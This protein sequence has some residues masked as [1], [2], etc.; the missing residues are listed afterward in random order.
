MCLSPRPLSRLLQWCWRLPKLQLR[1]WLPAWC[2]P[3]LLQDSAG[4]Q[5]SRDQEPPQLQLCRVQHAFRVGAQAG[6]FNLSFDTARHQVGAVAWA[7]SVGY[8]DIGQKPFWENSLALWHSCSAHLKWSHRLAQ[9][10]CAAW[11]RL[12]ASAS[13][14][15]ASRA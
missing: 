2:L 13:V 3:G 6:T 15:S 7:A 5:C 14:P 8:I 11:G 4:G 10:A 9:T 12:V 1:R